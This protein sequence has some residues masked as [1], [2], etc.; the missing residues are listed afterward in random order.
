MKE[1]WTGQTGTLEVVFQQRLR[2]GGFGGAGKGELWHSRCMDVFRLL[3]AHCWN[4]R[5]SCYKCG[6]PRHALD[7]GL[8]RGSQRVV[9]AKSGGFR[10]QGGF[11][12]R[13]VGPN[14][15]DQTYTPGGDPTFRKGA[16]AKVSFGTWAPFRWKGKSCLDSEASS[17]WLGHGDVFVMEWA[18][19]GRVSSLYGSRSGAGADLRYVPL[20]QAACYFLSIADGSGMLSANVCAGFIRCCYGD[21]GDRWFWG[22]LGAL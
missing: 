15:R 10:G 21:C 4:T 7:G 3:C 22:F 8:V 20:D 13:I 9:P 6:T 16:G 19:S 11:G 2:S 18:V 17:C 1:R 12:V 14:G 5:Y